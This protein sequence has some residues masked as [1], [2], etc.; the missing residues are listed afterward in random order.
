MSSSSRTDFV[1][2]TSIT[3]DDN[4][5]PQIRLPSEENV[6]RCY[7]SSMNNAIVDTPPIQRKSIRK[8]TADLVLQKIKYIY[9][10]A[11]IPT[12]SDEGIRKQIFNLLDE[13]QKLNKIPLQIRSK[14]HIQGKVKDFLLR[15]Q[16]TTLACWKSD[17]SLL[18]EDKEFLENMKTDRTFT[19][20]SLDLKR[21]QVAERKADKLRRQ[22]DYRK[23]SNKEC[24]AAKQ[25]VS[26]E[27][28]VIDDDCNT[29]NDEEDKDFQAASEMNETPAKR[30]H[31]H[32]H[33]H[34][35]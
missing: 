33:F 1:L 17:A 2:G 31:R 35:S 26:S 29:M 12:I 7:L 4:F 6:L 28:M 10:K 21:L 11:S 22:D 3:S 16:T 24:A 23:K 18:D 8:K 5:I 15:I 19:I 25:T 20:G 30:R 13:Y 14:D 32:K 27:S 34:S 9:E